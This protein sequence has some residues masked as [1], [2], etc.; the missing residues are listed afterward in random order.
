MALTGLIMW[1][2]AGQCAAER[3]IGQPP[4][5]VEMSQGPCGAEGYVPRETSP[6]DHRG[7]GLCFT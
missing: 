1:G 2:R 5:G 7:S 4:L 6:V 3:L